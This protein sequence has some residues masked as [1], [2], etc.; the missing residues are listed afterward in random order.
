M[1]IA[2][3][4][5]EKC[6]SFIKDNTNKTE[7][8]LEKIQYGIHV[9]L[10]NIF[11]LILLFTTAYF[12]GI[13]NYTIVAYVSFATLRS[14]ANGIHA[15]SSIKCIITNY[16]IFFGNV[17]LSL[18]FSLKKVYVATIFVISLIL[19]ILYA[20]ADTEERPLMSKNLRGKL[21]FKSI[22][23]VLGFGIVT[24]LLP[25]SVYTNLITY[26]TLQES[27]LITPMIYIIFEKKYKNYERIKI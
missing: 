27:I 4:L 2:E 24:L 17:Y 12:L 10:I 7:T 23:I 8:E 16:I 9:I 26:S 25:G 1:D 19:V 13:L 18:N 11:K 3:K 14:F 5:S 20:P 22:L 6:T 21:K 15:D